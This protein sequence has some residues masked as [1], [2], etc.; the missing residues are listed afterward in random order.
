MQAANGNYWKYLTPT[1]RPDFHDK[2]DSQGLFI[3]LLKVNT[4]RTT[5]QLH[6]KRLLKE[7]REIANAIQ[8]FFVTF[9]PALY[10]KPDSVFRA[11]NVSEDRIDSVER[12]EWFVSFF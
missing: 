8:V 9:Y 12:Q 5:P 1:N 4:V 11:D 10:A 6:S 2:I 7:T 3:Q